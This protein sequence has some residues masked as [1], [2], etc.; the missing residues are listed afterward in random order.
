MSGTLMMCDS[1]FLIFQPNIGIDVLV[2][3]SEY[4]FLSLLLYNRCC[5]D[6]KPFLLLGFSCTPYSGLLKLLTFLFPRRD[7]LLLSF[8]FNINLDGPTLLGFLDGCRTTLVKIILSSRLVFESTWLIAWLSRKL[9]L[10]QLSYFEF[11]DKSP[12]PMLSLSKA[13]RGDFNF[14]FSCTVIS[15]R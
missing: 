12:L 13:K 9:I 1:F 6:F 7:F 4:S 11:V 14:V 10:E 15:W 2:F 5:G 8:F 3:L